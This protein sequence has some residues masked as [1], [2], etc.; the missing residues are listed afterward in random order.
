VI[1]PDLDVTEVHVIREQLWAQPGQYA[2]VPWKWTYSYAIP[3]D[4]SMRLHGPGLKGL[5]DM[6]RRAYPNAKII[7]A[8]RTE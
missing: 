5:R 2:R 3:G 1:K 4:L 8:W 6:L 7:E